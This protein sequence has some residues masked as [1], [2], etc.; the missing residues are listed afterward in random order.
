MRA[1]MLRHS[2]SLRSSECAESRDS[3]L[4]ASCGRPRPQG[5]RMTRSSYMIPVTSFAGKTVAVFGLGGSGL[6]S[7]HALK[8]GGAE[9]IASDD[10]ADNLAKAAQA[11]FITADLRTVSWANFAALVLAPGVPLTHPKPH[12]SVLAA[13]QA[14]VEVIGDIELFC[15]ERQAPCARC[16]V[17]RDHRHQRQIHHHGAGR[18]SDAR[19]RARRAD[20][21]QHRHRDPVA[22]AAAQGPRACHRDVVV[23]DRP[24]ALARSDRRHPAQCQS[25]II[26]IVTAAS[27]TT[28]R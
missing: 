19:G 21:R 4:R 13:R 2:G 18:A 26:S 15:R 1:V 9:V 12:W 16:A 17:R 3:G 27:S 10:N 25:P 14:G 24:H 22:G 8:A 28:R 20:G 7:C 5:E 6:A 23:P 11:G